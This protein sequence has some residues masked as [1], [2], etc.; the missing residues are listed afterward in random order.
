[1]E[2]LARLGVGELILVD[3]DRVTNGRTSIRIVNSNAGDARR[4]GRF[5]VKVLARTIR[6]LK[7]ENQSPSPCRGCSAHRKVVSALA[8]CDLLFG[9][10]DS[11]PM[12]GMVAARLRHI[13]GT[14]WGRKRYMDMSHFKDLAPAPA[15]PNNLVAGEFA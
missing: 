9:C 1:M 4:S 6:R 10:V 8:G 12:D 13:V 5:K 14:Q 15:A 3:P 7:I 2:M 11:S